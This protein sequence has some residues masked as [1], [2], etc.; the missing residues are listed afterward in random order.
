MVSI[1]TKVKLMREVLLYKKALVNVLYYQ[2]LGMSKEEL[3]PVLFFDE[4]TTDHWSLKKC[5]VQYVHD[6][7]QYIEFGNLNEEACETWN[8]IFNKGITD[9]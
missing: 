3:Q 2:A 8:I 1:P 5:R 4:E 6:Q 9:E 7:L